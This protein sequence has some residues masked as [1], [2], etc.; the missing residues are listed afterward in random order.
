M[1]VGTDA[2]PAP[3]YATRRV[4]DDAPVAL[5]E[6]AWLAIVDKPEGLLSVPGRSGALRD[7]AL[8]RLRARYA[9]ATLVHRLDLDTSGLLICAKDADT[10][11][12]LQAMFARREID[13][14]YDA[15]LDGDVA[16]DSG[17]VELPLRVDLD[18]RPRQIV[19]PVHGKAA[20][21]GWRVI[22]REDGRT[23]VALMPRTGRAHQLRVHAAHPQGIGVPIV[24]DR[25]YGRVADRLLL[26]AAHI[27]FVHPV[28]G[29]NI[30]VDLPAPF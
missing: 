23:R 13:K 1:L 24:G 7:S 30:A 9:G 5:Y 25:L 4:P 3:E 18:D 20:F 12:R 16:G 27:A 21:T 29:E 15:W 26:H 10:H 11:A 2:E 22:A 8:T 19:D 14:R 17:V 6:D 28:T